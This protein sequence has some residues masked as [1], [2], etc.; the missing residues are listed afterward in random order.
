MVG[1]STLASIIFD[2]R[3]NLQRLV[4]EFSLNDMTLPLLFETS[5]KTR[6]NM[7]VLNIGLI[8]STK[9]V[10]EASKVFFFFF[11]NCYNNYKYPNSD[12]FDLCRLQTSTL[13]LLLQ[14]TFMPNMR[15]T[16]LFT[17]ALHLL[18]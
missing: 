1:L 15:L 18:H 14:P 11:L 4:L 6:L 9:M 8:K 12:N 5:N 7:H 2:W 13:L 16:F 10:D 17:Q 3:Y